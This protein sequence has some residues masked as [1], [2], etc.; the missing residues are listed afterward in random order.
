MKLIGLLLSIF[1]SSLTYSQTMTLS[2]LEKFH[3]L[4]SFKDREALIVGK[5]FALTEDKPYPDGNGRRRTVFS[6]GVIGSA[7][8]SF[9]KEIIL[10][11][12]NT[13][14]SGFT[15]KTH[16]VISY[17]RLIKAIKLKYKKDSET[18]EDNGVST[19]IYTGK[20]RKISIVVDKE[21]NNA[22][23]S[24]SFQFSGI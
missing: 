10:C 6:K 5:G 7:K 13:P 1:I 15:Y 19:V 11:D 18:K 20:N 4:S 17:N 12:S 9:P 22:H 24:Y 16:D 21:N 8:E 2:T 23:T 14:S 3:S